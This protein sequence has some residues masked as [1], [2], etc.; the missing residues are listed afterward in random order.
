MGKLK[1]MKSGGGGGLKRISRPPMPARPQI[2]ISRPQ[3]APRPAAAPLPRGA[4]TNRIV[5]REV[6]RE[7][8]QQQVA[9]QQTQT[10]RFGVRPASQPHKIMPKQPAP[11]VRP[12]N[13]LRP[14]NTVRPQGMVRPNAFSFG[15]G[16]NV[17]AQAAKPAAQHQGIQGVQ[18]QRP[19]VVRPPKP[20]SAGLKS[21]PKRPTGQ[22]PQAPQVP[23]G[24]VRPPMPQSVVRPGYSGVGAAAGAAILSSL[25]LNSGAAHPQIS[26]E[27][28]SLDYS[29]ADLR[30]RS[31]LSQVQADI[32]QIDSSINHAVSL[33]E[34]ARS[35]GYVYQKD[36]DEIAYQAMD[37]WQPVRDQVLQ[38]ISQQAT[39]FQSRLGGLSGQ[40][41]SLNAVLGNPQAASYQLGNTTSQVN[42]LLGELG[43]IERTLQASYADIQ[44]AVSTLTSRLNG[45]HWG[46][47]QLSEAKFKLADGE[48]LVTTVQARW[49]QVGDD[50]PEGLLFLTNKR[51]IFERK[52]KVATK[53]ILFFTTSTE[54]VHEVMIDQ[55]MTNIKDTKAINK[56]L[57]GHQDFL[58]VA[59][60]DP[61]LGAVPFHL[62]GQDCK[63]W[64]VLIQR[65]KSGDI[66]SDRTSGSGLSFS[67]LTGSLSAAD[68][69]NLQ[70]EVNAL[71]DV[72]TLK[73]VREELGAIE[74]D[75]RSLERDLGGLRSRGYVIE[76]SLEADVAVLATQWDRIKTNAVTSLETQTRLLSGQMVDIQKNMAALAGQSNNLKAAR[77]LFMQVKSAV[78]SA[79]AQADA[80]DDAVIAQYDQYADEVEALTA[81]LAWVGWMLDALATAT[82][83]LLA[84]ESGVAATEAVFARPGFELENGILFL[85]DQR[86]LWEDRVDTFELKLDVPLVQ[87]AD[88]QKTVDEASGQE[89]LNF[90]FAA[91]APY[92]SGQFVLSLPVADAWL[93]MVGR[94]RSGDYAKDRAVEIDEAELERIRNAP[95]QC[96]NCGAGL[97]APILRGQTD[98]T[99]EYCGQVIR[100]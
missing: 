93:K 98:I 37:R 99:C 21:L 48:N 91:G 73:A 87:V 15:Q 49:D 76:K 32:A 82:F 12:L 4:N 1:P 94:A 85:T 77:P 39:N 55:P 88:V 33:L 19:G 23:Q 92:S 43:Q 5:A 14:Q 53:K 84:T 10:P 51:L 16:Q 18:K 69:V 71:Q 38:S 40:V 72:V 34:S 50:D 81:H 17:L 74:N 62:N 29:L 89:F 47:S 79:E 65:C 78:A 75:M 30:D 6:K 90:N 26:T 100:I 8:F 31:S 42:T 13:T 58:E 11:T 54:L 57:F 45:V 68:L 86:L 9:K 52:E 61:R 35:K 80:A 41:S 96:S 97:T 83:Q 63:D 27:V 66:E 22:V 24:V 70:S 44:D 25:I 46:L 28:S 20:P 7:A 60:T 95:K 67:D 56:G 2:N 59:F 64:T 3:A 36:L